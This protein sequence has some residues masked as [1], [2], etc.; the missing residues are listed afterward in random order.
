MTVVTVFHLVGFQIPENIKFLIFFL[1]LMIYCVTICGNLLIITLVSY[2]KTLHSPMYFFLAQLAMSDM[3]LST[4][5][6]PNT[7]HT[8]LA[9]NT[10]I[11]SFT[12]CFTQFY[13][14]A[15]TETVESLF[16]TVMSYDRYLAICKPLHYPLL[17]NH[18]LCWTMIA[19]CWTLSFVTQ[20]LHTFSVSRLHFCGNVIDHFFCDLDPILHL[21][22]SDT[23]IVQLETTALSAVFAV[24]PF[25][26]IIVSYV[27]I[28]I[29]IFQIPSITGRQKVFST[30][31]SHLTVVFI[32]YGTIVCIYL[33]PKR[34]QSWN[35]TKLVSLLYTVV[36]PLLNPMI[37]SLRNK[38]LKNVVGKSVRMFL[39]LDVSR[40]QN[41]QM[42]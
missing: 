38:D 6:L 17:M 41:V 31:S 35:V 29:T 28:I 20:S 9:G 21:S 5:V 11:V 25:I 24:I 4:D 1:F 3:L 34:V 8:V 2:S 22:C 18:R 15:A 37:Y 39:N 10:I 13:F 16:L 32:F 19:T 26:V 42:T 23:T 30:C 40:H 12:D 14:F 33:V 27:Y 36:T 7:L